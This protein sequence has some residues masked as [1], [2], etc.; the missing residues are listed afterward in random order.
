MGDFVS[1]EMGGGV[2]VGED[3][4]IVLWGS[5][6]DRKIKNCKS[7]YGSRDRCYLHYSQFRVLGGMFLL[8]LNLKNY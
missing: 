1:Q 8:I 4:Y 7:G 5:V 3:G 2:P 6:L